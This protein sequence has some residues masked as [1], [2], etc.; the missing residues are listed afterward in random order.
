MWGTYIA[1][2]NLDPK[3][4]N[5]VD[6]KFTKAKGSRFGVGF[7]VAVVSVNLE[8]QDIKYGSTELE[9]LGPFSN[10]NAQDDIELTEKGLVASVSF[11][12]SL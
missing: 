3:E 9:K 8:Y 7:H 12:M 6:L 11:P 2:G 1:D 10:I 4:D 5:N